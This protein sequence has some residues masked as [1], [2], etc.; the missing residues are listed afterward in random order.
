MSQISLEKGEQLKELIATYWQ[1]AADAISWDTELSSHQLKHV[2]SLRTLRFLASVEDRFH[3]NIEDPEV[4]KSF[5][6]L[7][8]LVTEA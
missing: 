3:V 1:I 7:L 2:S 6:D 8:K 5:R 4:I